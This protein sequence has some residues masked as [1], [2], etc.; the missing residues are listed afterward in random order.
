MALNRRRLL[1]VST[2]GIAG[3]LA[4][5]TSSLAQNQISSGEKP[6]DGIEITNVVNR[7][8]I[9]SDLRDWEAVRDCFTEQVNVDYTSLA[10]GQ[11]EAIAADALV[12]RWKSVFETTFKTT[13]H[14]LGSH[15]ITING[16]IATCVSHFQAHHIPLDSTKDPWTLGGYYSH[17][18]VRQNSQW[19]VSRMK[20]VWTWED[21]QR[22]FA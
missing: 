22:P 13:Q 4:A 17:E 12:E 16:D 3:L 21:G 15:S 14:L 6:M 11:P 1:I 7:I 9:M 8:A 20:M 5:A 19:L 18:L 10:G 2:A